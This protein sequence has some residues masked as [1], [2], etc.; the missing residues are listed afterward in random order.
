MN[1]SE[2]ACP[3]C[4]NI[5]ELEAVIC[6]QCGAVLDDPFA[7][8]GAKTKTTDMP[9]L[10][11]EKFKGWSIDEATVPGDAIAVYLEGVYSPAYIDT[12]AEFVIGRKV[13]DLSEGLLDLAPFGAYHLGLSRRHAVIRRTEHGYEVIDLGSV[14]GTWLNNERLIPHKPY[15]LASGSHLRLGSMRLIMLYRSRIKPN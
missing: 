12:R 3:V 10:D 9:A 14:N 8:P 1:V 2:R 7:D 11:P 6:S 15:P 4:R 13:D 5:N